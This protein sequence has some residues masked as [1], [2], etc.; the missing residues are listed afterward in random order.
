MAQQRLN[1]H[2][3]VGHTWTNT[4]NKFMTTCDFTQLEQQG[5][6]VVRDFLSRSEIDWFLRDY[7]RMIE[8]SES[9]G[10]HNKNH[11]VAACE[12]PDNTFEHLNKFLA[13]IR[14]NS[15]FKT[16]FFLGQ[17]GLYLNSEL[18]SY[19]WHQDHELYYMCQHAYDVLTFWLPLDKPNRNET[20]LSFIPHDRLRE[21]IPEIYD[22]LI[23]NRGAKIFRTDGTETTIRDDT[24]GEVV[25]LDFDI[26]EIAVS[27][28]VGS[29]DLLIFRGDTIHKTQDLT[30]HRIAMVTRSANGNQ[31]ITRETLTGGY[32]LKQSKIRNSSRVFKR[33]FA[34]L[35][36]VDQ[37]ILRTAFD[38]EFVQK[39]NEK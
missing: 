38:G 14:Q 6:L 11:K 32:D 18:V 28:E 33:F 19:D 22:R 9:N 12:I 8:Y 17:F 5:Y 24:T 20:G 4:L 16:D 37:C 31:I 30:T 10:Y 15:N 3:E 7:S 13:H 36:T 26:N 35:E 1:R 27:P 39:H 21:R 23:F 2:G 25:K 34:A 29:G